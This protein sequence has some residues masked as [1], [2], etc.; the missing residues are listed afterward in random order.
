MSLRNLFSIRNHKHSKFNTLLSLLLTILMF[1]NLKKDGCILEDEKAL[2][3]S[4]LDDCEAK[5]NKL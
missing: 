3:E 1:S 2:L 5:L 4:L